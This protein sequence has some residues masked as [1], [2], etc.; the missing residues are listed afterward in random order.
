MA[1]YLKPRRGTATKRAASTVV[2]QQGEIFFEYPDSGAGKGIGRVFMGDGSTQ[3]KSLTPFLEQ[4]AATNVAGSTITF[5]T[6]TQTTI[7]NA[8]SKIA[9]GSTLA[10]LI[11]AIKNALNLIN[12]SVTKLNNDLDNKINIDWIYLCD[13]SL[14]STLTVITDPIPNSANEILIR[15]G[16]SYQTHQT[17]I[18]P[19]SVLFSDQDIYLYDPIN[20]VQQTISFNASTRKITLQ[21]CTK[22]EWVSF[23]YYR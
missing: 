8:I 23:I 13:T 3:L 22:R 6:G 5:T 17:T 16:Y 19:I 10:V 20:M 11:G 9:S 1:K 15:F 21:P 2:L 7:A 4:R 12:T 14:N 18:L